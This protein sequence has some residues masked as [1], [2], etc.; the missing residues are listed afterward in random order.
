MPFTPFHMGAGLAA[1]AA[2]DRH[3]SVLTFGIAQIAMDIEPL[4]G[5]IRDVDVLHGPTHTYIGAL[6]IGFA[7]M[8]V[9]PFICRPIL[10]RYN[11]E[12]RAMRASW[13]ACPEHFSKGAVA[14]GAFI[15][16]LSHV[17]LDSL[18]HADVRPFWPVSNSNPL[19]GL[20]SVDAVYQLCFWLGVA[21]AIA[22]LVGKYR[23]G[24]QNG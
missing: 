11:Y 5:M 17:L 18:M 12:A 6:A 3:F 19:L 22:W 10:R 7:V 21:S 9:S 1:K 20:V 16:T 2:L 24:R 14:L 4:I 15:G 8:L 23:H 13:L